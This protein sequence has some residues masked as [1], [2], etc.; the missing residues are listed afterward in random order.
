MSSISFLNQISSQVRNTK[1]PLTNVNLS[2]FEGVQKDIP[3]FKNVLLEDIAFLTKRF[4]TLNLFRGCS[5]GCS[6]CLKDAKPIKNGTVLFEDLERFLD[7]F[8]LLSERFGFNVLQGNKYL[9]IIDDSNPSDIPIRGKSRTHSVIEGMKLI[10]DKINIPTIFVTSGWNRA[11]KYAEAN[12]NELVYMI[13]KN[14]NS[15]AS[16]EVSINPFSSLMEKSRNALKND[17]KINADFFRNI[18]TERM[19]HTLA[20]FLKLFE[21][22]KA[23]VI[24]RH[25]PDYKKNELV[26]E[27]ETRRLYEEIFSKLRKKVGSELENIPNLKPEIL[28]AFD[29]SHLIE[30][31]GRGRQYFP[32]EVNLKEQ[33]ELIKEALEWDI[34]SPE[35]KRKE[36][37][38]YSIKCVDINGK[39]YTTMPAKKVDFISAPIEI[40]VPTN[41]RLNYENKTEFSPI[42]SDIELE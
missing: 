37:L 23:K 36:L 22:G 26:G 10:Y 24:Y 28:T 15:V 25:A 32:P 42:F 7:G 29:K 19:A 21:N 16:V 20:V 33:N 5:V 8:K 30:S 39:V 2:Q 35:E 9:N 13:Q 18:Y 14:P 1:Y 4:E 27:K 38:D 34:L 11:S 6:H 40:T 3:L 17:N 31:S 41:I 12:A